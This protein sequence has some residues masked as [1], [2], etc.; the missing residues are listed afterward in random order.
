MNDEPDYLPEVLSYC[1]AHLDHPSDLRVAL[2][3]L[4]GDERSYREPRGQPANGL[5]RFLHDAVLTDSAFTRHLDDGGEPVTR[6]LVDGLWRPV[7]GT[8]H[9]PTA[10]RNTAFEFDVCISFA[11]RDRP[12]ADAI[13]HELALNGMNRRVFYDD[14]ERHRTWGHNLYEYLDSIYSRKSLF[15]VILFSHEYV[16]GAWTMHEMD[17]V[18]ARLKDSP[19]YVLPVELEPGVIPEDFAAI[20]YWTY[21]ADDEASIAALVEE[22]INEWG[23]RTHFTLEEV[24]ARISRDLAA[25]AIGTELLKVATD[26]ERAARA[27]RGDVL[28]LIA[29][30]FA[31]DLDKAHRSVRS[32]VELVLFSP[33]AVADEFG[34]DDRLEVADERTVMRW[35]GTE[36]PLMLSDN[37]SAWMQERRSRDTHDGVDPGQSD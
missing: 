31:S 3:A 23:V 33:G 8:K 29:L 15:C 10:S 1:E 9:E 12:V 19:D 2:G 36:G 26:L 6:R 32:L 20:S 13:A 22:R 34:E 21:Q 25:E 11:G 30:L 17:S 16:S 27:P 18:K 35:T 4:L 28:R 5:A 37:W 24:S 7:W 14:F